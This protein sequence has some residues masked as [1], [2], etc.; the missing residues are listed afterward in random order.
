MKRHVQSGR[1]SADR[2]RSREFAAGISRRDLLTSAAV[3]GAGSLLPTTGLIAQVASSESAAKAGRIDVHNHLTPPILLQTMG[4]EELG[5]FA[6][7][8]PEKALEEMEKAG[9]TT[10]ITSIPPHYDPNTVDRIARPSN[11]YAARL[12][13]DHPGKFGVFAFVPMP[14]IDNTLKE[15][16]YAYDTLKVDGIG[17]YTNYGD[18]WL[19]DPYFDPVFEELERRKAVVFTHPITADC[20]KNLIKGIGDGAIEWQTDTTRAIAQMIFGGAAA[21]YP[22]VRMIWSHGGGTMPYL[23]ER[24]TGMAKSPRY[25]SK[26]PGGFEAAAG[27]FYYDTAQVANPPAMSALTKVV[28][29]SQ[30]VFG[31]DYPARTLAEHVKGLKECGVFGPKE[32]QQID[33]DNALAL[34]PRFRT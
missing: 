27:R 8:T 33:R 19:G 15:I 30:I 4:A 14:H 26:F 9:V 21:R 23:I 5:G 2:E 24:F 7:W 16:E 3:L 22:N 12:A 20:C 25:A 31:T 10:G 11:E 13:A 29:I 6:K 18:K 28:P 17:M 32:L 1:D 34:L